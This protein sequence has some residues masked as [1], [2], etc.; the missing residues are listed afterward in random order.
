MASLPILYKL[1]TKH[2]KDIDEFFNGKRENFKMNNFN[3]DSNLNS[4]NNFNSDSN[5]NS[6]SNFNYDPDYDDINQPIDTD[7]EENQKMATGLVVAIIVII[8]VNLGLYIWCIIALVKNKKYMEDS[9]GSAN[10]AW[11]ASLILLLLFGP[12]IPLIII[13]ATRKK[14]H[15]SIK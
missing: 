5:F 7:L 1:Y 14:T 15:L 10:G 3:S 2:K 13:Y 6:G 9:N 11:I 4:N 8:L 12:V